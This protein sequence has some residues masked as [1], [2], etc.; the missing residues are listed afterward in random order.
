MGKTGTD[1]TFRFDAG[2]L[3]LDEIARRASD[4]WA[5]LPWDRESLAR[6]KRDGL[7]FDGLNLGG[8][9]P[10]RFAL[11]AGGLTVVTAE[12]DDLA[13]TLLDLWQVHF[14][15]GFRSRYLAA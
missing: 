3:T 6:L 7:T 11:D 1:T 14:L 9:C 4:M 12:P 15:R 10:Y 8:A 5:D 2:D 13:G